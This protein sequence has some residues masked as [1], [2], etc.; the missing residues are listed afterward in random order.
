MMPSTWSAAPGRST[1]FVTGASLGSVADGFD[2]VPIRIPHEG[3]EVVLVVLR[4]DLR[5][6]EDLGPIGHGC[7]EKC[8]HLGAVGGGEG[9]VALSEPIPVTE[10]PHP[11]HRPVGP[12][13]GDV[14]GMDEWLTAQWS[15]NPCVEP[16]TGRLVGAL[17]REVVE[18]GLILPRCRPSV[19]RA[20]L[21]VIRRGNVGRW[22]HLARPP[23]R[24]RRPSSTVWPVVEQQVVVKP[25]WALPAADPATPWPAEEWPAGE[26]P[27]GVDL[28]HLMD[29]AFDA[30]GPVQDTYAVV[31]VHH[32]RLVFERYGGLLPQWDKPGKPVVRD[33]PLLSWSMAKSML[34]SVV[35]MLVAEGRLGLHDPAPVPLWGKVGDPRGAITLQD[36][37]EMRDGLDFVEDYDDPEASDVLA[38]LFGAGRADMAEFA[39]DRPLAAPPGTRF[40]YSSGTSNVISGIVGRLVGTGDAYRQLLRDRL[41]DP[42]GMASA[43]ASFDDAG[44]WIAASYVHASA[45]DYARFGLLYLR[46]GL[47]SGRRLLPAGWV[48]HGRTPRSVDPDDGDYYGAHWWTRDG[49]LGTFWA[50]GHEGQFIDV[51]PAL[52]LVLVRMGRTDSDHSDALKRWR[53]QV[54]EAFVPARDE[55]EA[56][57]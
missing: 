21:G 10:C 35:G 7:V 43:E 33:T 29:E 40:S 31:I 6:M 22:A 45:R 44:N 48:D 3:P 36:L 57:G 20:R 42:L 32:G 15:E 13:P 27:S 17:D 26:L 24:H 18:H 4:S 28:G 37:L 52:D 34:H 2:I 53:T 1:L 19:G 38:M 23:A 47:W 11:E 39:A 8:G 49:P 9:D 16:D 41:F 56:H 25:L 55:G 14:F 5:C 12:E 50:S 51:C 46:D 54:I 30:G